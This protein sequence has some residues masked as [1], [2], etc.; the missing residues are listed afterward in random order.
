[1]LDNNE[2]IHFSK[3]LLNDPTMEE[4]ESVA[5]ILFYHREV[6]SIS[7]TTDYIPGDI[8]GQNARTRFYRNL[9]IILRNDSVIKIEL[10][11]FREDRD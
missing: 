4:F 6:K 3:Q 9:T 5:T 10:E 8:T 2:L 11:S 1:M 7:I